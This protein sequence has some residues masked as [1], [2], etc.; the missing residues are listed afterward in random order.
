MNGKNVMV[1]NLK[2]LSTF[3]PHESMIFPFLDSKVIG[4]L[5]FVPVVSLVAKKASKIT[6]FFDNV[7][8]GLESP[9]KM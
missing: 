6:C 4:E 8:V 1:A 3:P 9:N 7:D 5:H 2:I